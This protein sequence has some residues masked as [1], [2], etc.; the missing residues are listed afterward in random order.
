V[1][2]E[3]GAYGVLTRTVAE[4]IEGGW[5]AGCDPDALAVLAWSAVHGLAVL[6]RDGQFA[7][8]HPAPERLAGDVAAALAHLGRPRDARAG[9]PQEPPVRAAA[10]GQPGRTSA[11]AVPRVRST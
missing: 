2:A 1:A 7:G 5:G 9:R 3:A 4:A 8:R 6:E 11:S 10:P